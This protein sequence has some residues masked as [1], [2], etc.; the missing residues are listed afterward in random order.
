VSGAFLTS[1]LLASI[2]VEHGFGTGDAEAQTALVATRV[3]QVHGKTLVRAPTGEATEADAIWSSTA[4]HAV[5]VRTAD[6]VPVLVCD[7][8]GRAVLAIHA[9]WRGTGAAIAHAAVLEF[10]RLVGREPGELSTAIG[11]HIGPCCYEV[12]EPVRSAIA[13]PVFAAADRPGHYMLDL[14]AANRAQLLRAGVRADRIE[15]V[16]GCT[17]CDPA[18]LPSYRRDGRGRE[19]LHFVRPRA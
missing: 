11:P 1:E 14:F 15:R 5:A 9:G 13:E 16:G 3:R 17:F 12:D 10:G 8:A 19:M 2:G 18:G 6:C 4:E 7:P